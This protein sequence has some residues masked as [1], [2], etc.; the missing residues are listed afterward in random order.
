M[1]LS[2]GV[3]L[4]LMSAGGWLAVGATAFGAYLNPGATE[5][6]AAWLLGAPPAGHVETVPEP[7][8]VAKFDRSEIAAVE[9]RLRL[10]EARAAAAEAK[11]KAYEDGIA[12]HNVKARDAQE[13]A[14]RR[15]RQKSLFD[16]EIAADA[17]GHYRADAQI[18]GVSVTALIDTG[19]TEVA[20]T[21]EDARR[22]GISVSP[23]DFTGRSRTA[24][25]EGRY[26][27]VTVSEISIGNISVQN[28][29]AHV[30]EPGKLSITLLGMS[31]LGRLSRADMRNGVLVLQ[32]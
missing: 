20:L 24:N 4:M 32:Q 3:R 21:Y 23:R 13:Q 5:A 6:A 8:P 17:M 31:F 19:A 27:P 7:T 22:I 15:A 25:G 11:V 16:T 18:N 26:A 2:S 28:V 29:R 12:A 30:T 9:A 1:A 14:Q 10:A